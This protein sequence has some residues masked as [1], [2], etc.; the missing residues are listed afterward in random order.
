MCTELKLI[1]HTQTFYV[2]F[3]Q[4]IKHITSP[5]RG[6]Y[7]SKFPVITTGKSFPLLDGLGKSFPFVST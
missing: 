4:S 1:H 5:D 2:T 7:F 3:I 6:E